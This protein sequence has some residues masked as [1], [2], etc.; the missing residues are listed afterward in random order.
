MGGTVA[1]AVGWVC[2]SGVGFAD[3]LLAT[4]VLLPVAV[5][6]TF[7]VAQPPTY[8]KRSEGAKKHNRQPTRSEAK[9][10]RSTTANLPEAK[11]RG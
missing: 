2:R 6:V 9:G 3:F 5:A 10:L 8:P 4:V 1:V 7:Q 11:R